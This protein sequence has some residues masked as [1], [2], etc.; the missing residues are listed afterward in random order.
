MTS[1]SSDKTVC[2]LPLV[3]DVVKLPI[4]SYERYTSIPGSDCATPCVPVPFPYVADLWDNFRIAQIVCVS[5]SLI[6]CVAV[7]WIHFDRKAG[8]NNLIPAYAI[9]FVPAAIS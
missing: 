6:S 4:E 7:F 3:E 2:P 8:L 9:S 1:L 5:L